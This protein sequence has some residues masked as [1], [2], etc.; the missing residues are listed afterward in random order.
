M[1]VNQFNRLGLFERCSYKIFNWQVGDSCR[2][3]C[4]LHVLNVQ[5]ALLQLYICSNC[6]FG[7]S[8]SEGIIDYA[9]TCT[10]LSADVMSDMLAR[11]VMCD[12]RD[13]RQDQAR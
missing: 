2:I 5:Y 9:F 1:S 8:I 4:I 12:V 11:G 10:M 13:A 3:L 7:V 6:G